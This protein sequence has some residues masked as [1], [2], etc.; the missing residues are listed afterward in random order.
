MLAA[1][2]VNVSQCKTAVHFC[3]EIDVPKVK[4]EHHAH[5]VRFWLVRAPSRAERVH[6]AG[7]RERGGLSGFRRIHHRVEEVEVGDRCISTATPG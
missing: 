3:S 7:D 1:A 2:R 4:C 6:Y 5:I